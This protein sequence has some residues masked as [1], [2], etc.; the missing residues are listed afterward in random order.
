MN[1][2]YTHKKENMQSWCSCMTLSHKVFCR[3]PEQGCDCRLPPARW[4]WQPLTLPVTDRQTDRRVQRRCLLTHA[5][6][7]HGIFFQLDA[8]ADFPWLIMKPLDV[9]R[10]L[11]MEHSAGQ[12]RFVMTAALFMKGSCVCYWKNNKRRLSI[13]QPP[14]Q[15]CGCSRYFYSSIHFWGHCSMISS[16]WI[17]QLVAVKALIL[18]YSKFPFLVFKGLT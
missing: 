1:M 8:P 11:I 7:R 4:Q 3:T 9:G 2:L 15:S 17:Y 16:Y 12:I 13:H 18:P 14:P 5:S 10:F 6:L